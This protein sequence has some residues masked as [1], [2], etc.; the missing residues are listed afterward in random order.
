MPFINDDGT[1]SR[2]GAVTSDHGTKPAEVRARRFWE[3]PEARA[4]QKR[5]ME[6]IAASKDMFRRGFFKRKAKKKHDAPSS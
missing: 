4:E 2:R 3:T 6:R 5:H 1:R